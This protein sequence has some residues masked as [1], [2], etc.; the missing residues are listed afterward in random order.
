LATKRQVEG[1]LRTLIKRLD[2]A[3]H[4]VRGSLADTLP[5]P[6]V[7]ELTVPDIEAVYWTELASGGMGE[8]H[9]GLPNR[10]DIRIRVASDHL[11]E[12]VDGKHSLFSSYLGGRVKIEASLGDLLRL[13]K[14]A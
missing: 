14:L 8:L 11:V 13:R 1:K 9:E 7:I 4:G 6:K 2:E 10:A 3:D 5:E 12:L